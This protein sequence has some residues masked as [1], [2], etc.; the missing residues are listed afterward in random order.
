MRNTDAAKPPAP[1]YKSLDLT[2][3][4]L[5][6]QNLPLPPDDSHARSFR[7][8]VKVEIHVGG[9]GGKGNIPSEAEAGKEAEGEYKAR[10][11][12][13]K[14]SNPDFGGEVLRFDR[15]GGVVPELTF[16]RFTVRDDEI[17][18]DDLAGWACVRL[19][20]V[21]GGYRF[22]HLMDCRGGL[23]EGVLLVKISRSLV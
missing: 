8:Y 22:V 2:V 19:D 6:A 20:R 18:R 16:V 5:A 11:K 13:V 1:T 3:E 23:T 9:P 17:G 14:G 12:T 7:P 4:V 21:R 10:T 15:I